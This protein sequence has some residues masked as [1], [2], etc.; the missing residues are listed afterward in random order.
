MYVK[1]ILIEDIPGRNSV[2]DPFSSN[3]Y[4]ENI[5]NLFFLKLL[6]GILRK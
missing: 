1:D 6:V 5:K 3:L 4:F 2:N